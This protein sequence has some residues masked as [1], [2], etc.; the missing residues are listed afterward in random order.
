MK[1]W[2]I[3]FALFVLFVSISLQLYKFYDANDS[4]IQIIDKQEEVSLN[5]FISRYSQSQ[6]SKIEL[7]DGMD[8]LWYVFLSSGANQ[9]M[10]SLNKSYVQEYYQVYTT[11][12]P[13]DTSLNDLMNI[14]YRLYSYRYTLFYQNF[15]S[16][17]LGRCL[18]ITSSFI[19]YY[20]FL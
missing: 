19:A 1:K 5:D 20:C 12:K 3:F 4:T 17:I 2:I 7:K 16:K 8:L 9:K 15:S 10:V 11:K 13:L 14:A 18:T 6:F